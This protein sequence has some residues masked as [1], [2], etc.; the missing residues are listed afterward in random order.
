MIQYYNQLK[1]SISKNLMVILIL[2]SVWYN[3]NTKMEALLI[4]NGINTGRISELKKQQ[5]NLLSRESNNS[6]DIK[7]LEGRYQNHIGVGKLEE[8]EDY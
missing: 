4:N 6:V 3:L 5:N 1:S 7:L 2:L 8:E